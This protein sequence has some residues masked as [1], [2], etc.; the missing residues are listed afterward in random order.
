MRFLCQCDKLAVRR[1]DT[2]HAEIERKGCALWQRGDDVAMA[3]A[4]LLLLAGGCGRSRAPE[5]EE[6]ARLS[7]IHPRAVPAGRRAIQSAGP[8]DARISQRRSSKTTKRRSGERKIIWPSA[9]MPEKEDV[10]IQRW[11]VEP[12]QVTMDTYQMVQLEDSHRQLG[13]DAWDALGPRLC[14]VPG[15][16]WED[17]GKLAVLGQQRAR[18]FR[19]EQQGEAEI[20]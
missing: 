8:R 10:T 12:G 4:G 13:A 1:R 17:R 2:R 5:I 6:S 7:R 19:A 3:L 15:E 14:A 16:R 9:S 11:E 18:F 20:H